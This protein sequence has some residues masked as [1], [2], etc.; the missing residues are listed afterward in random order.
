MRLTYV[1]SATVVIEHHGVKV[2]CDPWFTD[3]IFLGAWY[4]VPALTVEPEAFRDM[5]Y[6]YISHIH[7]DH[8]DIDALKRL[9]KKSVVLL[10][11]YAETFLRQI[12]EGRG[13]TVR[14]LQ[15]GEVFPLGPDFTVEIAAADN[16]DPEVC[17]RWFGCPIPNAVKGL[18]YQIDSLAVFQGGGRT[19]W[20]TNDCPYPLATPALDQLYTRYGSPDLLCVGYSGASAYPHCFAMPE[21]AMRAAADAKQ[22]KTL[23]FARSYVEHLQPRRVLPFAGQ[24]TL[25]SSLFPLNPY[26]GIPSLD[27][28][29]ALWPEPRMIRLNRMGWYDVDQDRQDA[30]YVPFPRAAVEARHAEIQGYPLAFEADPWP[31]AHEVIAAIDSAEQRL[32]QRCAERGLYSDWTVW[33]QWGNYR[34]PVIFH[35]QGGGAGTITLTL[36]ARLLMRLLKRRAHWNQAEIGSLIQYSREPEVYERTPYYA[37]SYFHV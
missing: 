36:D 4:H 15:P 7:Q 22:A 26:R 11:P 34:E 32:W 23:G 2:L 9:N 12:I 25:G 29:P 13:Y 5:D 17:G 35:D 3:G 30:P 1:A 20:N 24:Y 28:L 21:P 31:T 19:I 10:A 33:I 16:C 6:I 8:C 37:L 18:S 14:V 27:D